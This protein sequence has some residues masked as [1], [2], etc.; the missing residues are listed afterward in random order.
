MDDM[1]WETQPQ[2]VI[3]KKIHN[4]NQIKIGP[5]AKQLCC[6]VRD[7]GNRFLRGR[8]MWKRMTR[9]RGQKARH[10]AQFYPSDP[11]GSNNTMDVVVAVS[12][13]ARMLA[14]MKLA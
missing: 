9:A 5:I 14:T 8:T 11:F 2:S 10:T 6:P 7:H 1:S 3:K 13:I 4:N 12:R